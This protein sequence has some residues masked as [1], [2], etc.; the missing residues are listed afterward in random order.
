MVFY[1]I[2][3]YMRMSTQHTVCHTQIHIPFSHI[4]FLRPITDHTVLFVT[5]QHFLVYAPSQ[6]QR[7]PLYICCSFLSLIH[8]QKMFRRQNN[9]SRIG[10]RFKTSKHKITPWTECV[11][12]L[13]YA[14]LQWTRQFFCS[15]L[16][17]PLIFFWLLLLKNWRK[18]FS[19]NS[20]NF[21]L[22]FWIGIFVRLFANIQC[23][24]ENKRW[25]HRSKSK[26]KSKSERKKR[27]N[28][29]SF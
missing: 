23:N 24:P 6:T 14:E 17:L 28:V 18:A 3:K 16:S 2:S 4:H 26:S 8:S 11:N 19:S 21:V 13:G 9:K 25:K 29:S 22:L 27:G 1:S 12:I 7:F 20:V 10:L 5:A 15:F